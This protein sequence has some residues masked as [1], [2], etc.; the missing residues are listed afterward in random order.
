MRGLLAAALQLP[1]IEQLG[2]VVDNGFVG[3]V[4]FAEQ[5]LARVFQG[6]E[7]VEPLQEGD[8]KLALVGK[9]RVYLWADLW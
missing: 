3:A 5:D 1:V 8:V 6:V 7:V 2:G 9:L 4:V